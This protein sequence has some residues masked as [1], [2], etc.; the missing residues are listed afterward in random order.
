FANVSVDYYVIKKTNVIV[1]PDTATGLSEYFA[2]QPTPGYV[3]TLDNPDPQ[4]P[5]APPRP[6]VVA[7][8]YLNANSLQT[9]GIDIDLR[10]RANLPGA[11]RYRGNISAPKI[12]RWQLTLPARPPA[13]QPSPGTAAP[14]LPPP[15]PR[16]PRHRP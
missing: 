5:N 8:G 1:P 10:L 16:P 13:D 15:G 11:L 14:Y 9:D 4:F 6:T 2:G 3:I 7:S 12:L